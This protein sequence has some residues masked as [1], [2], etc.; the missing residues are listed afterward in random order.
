MYLISMIRFL[1][2][3]TRWRSSRSS[4]ERRASSRVIDISRV[5]RSSN[6]YYFAS[7]LVRWAIAAD[8]GKHKGLVIVEMRVDMCPPDWNFLVRESGSPES[9]LASRQGWAPRYRRLAATTRHSQRWAIVPREHR[10][11]R[12]RCRPVSDTP[13]K[14]RLPSNLYSVDPATSYIT[15]RNA[16]YCES[17]ERVNIKQTDYALQRVIFSIKSPPYFKLWSSSLHFR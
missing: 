11:S 16:R 4:S 7:R 1:F 17:K 8:T 14:H 15:K 10:R 12:D 5:S 2:R 6:G 3:C 13:V 9:R